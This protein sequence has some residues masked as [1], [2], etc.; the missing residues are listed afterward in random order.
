MNNPLLIMILTIIVIVSLGG[1]FYWYEYRPSNI[2]KDCMAY[3]QE[4][5]NRPGELTREGANTKYR[6]CL[7]RNGMK[8]EDLVKP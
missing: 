2:R 1:L 8:A 7:L 4:A 6:A 3:V 5:V